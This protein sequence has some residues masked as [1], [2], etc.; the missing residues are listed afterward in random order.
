VEQVAAS[1]D[2]RG[3]NLPMLPLGSSPRSAPCRGS[4]RVHGRGDRIEVGSTGAVSVQFPLA[5]LIAFWARSSFL[6]KFYG[7]S[8]GACFPVNSAKLAEDHRAA[9]DVQ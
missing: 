3:L 8:A 1:Q 9:M 4:S 2:G 5:C 7:A 6:S